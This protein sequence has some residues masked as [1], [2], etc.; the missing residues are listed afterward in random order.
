MRFQISQSPSEGLFTFQ[1][2]NNQDEILLESSPY[3]DRD[4]CTNAI[5]NAIQ[6]LNTGSN[7]VVQ[8]DLSLGLL[9]NEGIAYA[10]SSPFPSQEAATTAITDIVN[11]AAA[12]TQFDVA[13][14]QTTTRR[15]SQPSAPTPLSAAEIAALYNFLRLSQ[16]GE[17]GFELF[18]SEDNQEYYFHFNDADG[19]AVLYSRGFKT[20]GQRDKRIESVIRS[21]SLDSRYEIIE[22]PEGG[23][24][25]IIK[26][27]NGQEIARSR[28][29]NSREAAATSM[30]F[31]KG[32]VPSYAE[33]HIKKRP[34]RENKSK[35]T[36][37]FDVP[38]PD[39]NPGFARFRNSDNKQHYFHLNDQ[40]GQPV[41]YS[42]GYGS[43]RSRDNGVRSV[44]RNSVNPASYVAREE[45]GAYFFSI[46]AGNRQEVARSRTFPTAASRDAMIALLLTWIRQ[47]A[48]DYGVSFEDETT[49]T[50]ETFTL[51]API[52]P[53]G[54][55]GALAGGTGSGG[56][57]ADAAGDASEIE[58][59]T[60]TDGFDTSASAG[61]NE[62][63]QTGSFAFDG[64]S[65]VADT[66]EDT[67]TDGFE[68]DD[69]DST[70]S[71]KEDTQ[72]DGFEFDQDADATGSGNEG[73]TQTESFAFDGSAD[74]KQSSEEE[75]EEEEVFATADEDRGSFILQ[76][77][78]VLIAGL[79]L[80]LLL[81]F[82]L[83]GCF[84]G[85]A[86]LR[87]GVTGSPDEN[88]EMVAENDQGTAG[89]DVAG[90]LGAG[91]ANEPPVGGADDAMTTDDAPEGQGL[92]GVT[93]ADGT[94]STEGGDG[95]TT[96]SAAGETDA[97]A[98]ATTLGPN[99]LAL[100]FA[101]GSLEARIADILS[102]PGRE[103]PQTF[104]M[105]AVAFPVNS[106]K[107]NKSAYTQVDNLVKLLG[108]YPDI[109][110]EFQGHIDQTEDE[111]SARQFSGGEDITLSAIRA[112]CLLKKFEERSIDS[113]QLGFVGFGAT[114]PIANSSTESNRQQNR[115]LELRILTK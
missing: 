23:F 100:G 4:A 7:L 75:E 13:F 32:S 76:F 60:L 11:E 58:E 53:L 85:D 34:R 14:T 106:A 46:L 21:A 20:A 29:F 113:G 72:T 110:F 68:F 47:F 73:D 54:A 92:A 25:M 86:V 9:N 95:A 102:D 94:S 55:A 19:N 111:N 65:G 61:V 8:P 77:P 84:G 2:L 10:S 16:S 98:A 28:T 6:G 44:I 83:R 103:L 74:S 109:I 26:A 112:R 99:A 62:D 38:S 43:G 70:T 80:M 71:A 96:G 3:P 66:G 42:E 91:D 82:L 114:Q 33:E 39:N 1:L 63:T 93:A 69:S 31:L 41:L 45:N 37:L 56:D 67:Q 59:D 101:P 107:L 27:R 5:R 30:A 88:Q 89:Q 51:A 17:T 48:P 36:Y 81:F 15:R 50:T 90:T 87:P 108:S 115:R 97:N 78:W 79:L 40:E 52:L 35:D 18:Q 64:S 12:T 104:V 24:Y 22:S 105:D 57:G 49:S